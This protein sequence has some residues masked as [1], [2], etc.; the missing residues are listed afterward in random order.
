MKRFQFLLVL[1]V[2]ASGG[3]MATSIIGFN[4]NTKQALPDSNALASH[5]KPISLDRNTRSWANPASNHPLS[6]NRS[7]SIADQHHGQ[8]ISLSDSLD[9][10]LVTMTSAFNVDAKFPLAALLFGTTLL[11]FS[12]VSGE[13]TDD[14]QR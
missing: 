10:L 5:Y 14:K 11:G 13:G 4:I 3:A 9:T 12:L 6:G 2:L 7:G 8:M 1:A